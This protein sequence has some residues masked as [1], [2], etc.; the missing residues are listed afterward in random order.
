MTDPNAFPGRR[1][2]EARKLQRAKRLADPLYLELLRERFSRSSTSTWWPTPPAHKDA[3]TMQ[4]FR[5]LE[6]EEAAQSDEEVWPDGLVQNGRL[7]P[8]SP[9][10]AGDPAA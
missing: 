1:L 10:G 9:E 5:R 7:I 4:Y 8:E 3:E 6:L 2:T